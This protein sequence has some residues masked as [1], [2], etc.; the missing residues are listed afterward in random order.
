M[1]LS[2]VAK[3]LS[4]GAVGSV[5]NLRANRYETTNVRLVGATVFVIVISAAVYLLKTV[6]TLWWWSRG[7]ND[8]RKGWWRTNWPTVRR[9]PILQ[10]GTDANWQE[11][12]DIHGRG[13]H[14]RSADGSLWAWPGTDAYEFALMKPP[15]QP[16]YLGNVLNSCELFLSMSICG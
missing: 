4:M 15:K 9:H 1:T 11:L 3:H 7:T 2:W 6:G 12:A 5:A 14:T 16:Q 10:I 13:C 8:L